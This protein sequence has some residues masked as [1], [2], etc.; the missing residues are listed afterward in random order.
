MRLITLCT[1]KHYIIQRHFLLVPLDF[2]TIKREH[3]NRHY[4]TFAYYLAF[5]LA[6]APL[7]IFNSVLYNVIAY[8]LSGN[9]FEWSRFLMLLLSMA[10]LSFAC[11]IVGMFCGSMN[12]LKV[13]S[14]F[15]YEKLC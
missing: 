1:L 15:N 11:Q 2:P 4:S 10:T 8:P 12:N 14:F 6:D 13:K 9:P 7:L 3:F 5:N